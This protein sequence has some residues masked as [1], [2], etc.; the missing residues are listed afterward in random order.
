MVHFRIQKIEFNYENKPRKI[1][2]RIYYKNSKNKFFLYNVLRTW[3]TFCD[4]IKRFD[5]IKRNLKSKYY[6]PSKIKTKQILQEIE[7]EKQQKN[8]QLSREERRKNCK[9]KERCLEEFQSNQCE[10]IK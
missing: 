10:L 8:Q 2:A 9:C 1:T 3:D 6:T 5:T 7:Q 4:D